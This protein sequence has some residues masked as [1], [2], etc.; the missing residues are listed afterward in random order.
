MT[1]SKKNCFKKSIKMLLFIFLSL[2]IILT[3]SDLSYAGTSYPEKSSEPIRI[4]VEDE[5]ESKEIEIPILSNSSSEGLS[6][7]DDSGIKIQK[8][9]EPELF[10]SDLG[11]YCYYDGKIEYLDGTTLVEYIKISLYEGGA[12]TPYFEYGK[13]YKVTIPSGA[14]ENADSNSNNSDLIYIFTAPPL[15]ESYSLEIDNDNVTYQ[16]KVN[17]GTKPNAGNK[18]Y[19]YTIEE[20]QYIYYTEGLE[21]EDPYRLAQNKFTVEEIQSNDFQTKSISTTTSASTT[22]N[23]DTDNNISRSIPYVTALVGEEPK[24]DSNHNDAYLNY[25]I[26]ERGVLLDQLEV[27]PRLEEPRDVVIYS[28]SESDSTS[29]GYDYVLVA[30]FD[31]NIE[32][33]NIDV[34][35]KLISIKFGGKF[36]P[37]EIMN[38]QAAV[39]DNKL[40]IKM[41][42]AEFSDTSSFSINIPDGIIRNTGG[43]SNHEIMLVDNYYLPNLGS[44]DLGGI[45]EGESTLIPISSTAAINLLFKNFGKSFNKIISTGT[46]DGSSFYGANE[47]SGLAV[48]DTTGTFSL[49][50]SVW[51]Y[52][53]Y[54]DD[55]YAVNVLGL[56]PETE[57]TWVTIFQNDGFD[58]NV[59]IAQGH[60]EKFTTVPP[61]DTVFLYID[62]DNGMK[63]YD[64]DII[65][66]HFDQMI[67]SNVTSDMFEVKVNLGQNQEVTLVPDTDYSVINA[68]GLITIVLNRTAM[69]Y[70]KECIDDNSLGNVSAV[71]VSIID[72]TDFTPNISSDYLT[73]SVTVTLEDFT[74]SD[75]LYFLKNSPFNQYDDGF[76]GRF[77]DFST[78]EDTSYIDYGDASNYEIQL[79]GDSN[80]FKTIDATLTD[81]D[82]SIEKTAS[83]ELKF[84]L[85]DSGIL[86][87]KN[88]QANFISAKAICKNSALVTPTISSD[89]IF[90]MILNVDY[91]ET[92]DGGGIGPYTVYD[93]TWNPEDQKIIY[94][95]GDSIDS[96][97]INLSDIRLDLF[98]GADEVSPIKTYE[99]EFSSSR[100]ELGYIT[101]QL[102]EDMMNDMK[103]QTESYSNFY[104][105][106]RINS[107]DFDDEQFANRSISIS[108]INL[109]EDVINLDGVSYDTGTSDLMDYD[110]KVILTFSGEVKNIG[111]SN[112][113]I[114]EIDNNAVNGLFETADYTVSPLNFDVSAGETSDKVAIDI[115]YYK[116]AYFE[117]LENAV[118]RV[119]VNNGNNFLP[120]I[121]DVYNSN[122]AVIPNRIAEVSSLYL[123]DSSNDKVFNV[124]NFDKDLMYYTIPFLYSEY[125]SLMTYGAI[126]GNLVSSTSATNG[127]KDEDGNFKLTVT[128]EEGHISNEYEIHAE[129]NPYLLKEI[130]VNGTLI[131]QFDPRTKSY[132]I[133]IYDTDEEPT[134]TYS[135]DNGIPETIAA[136]GGKQ[137]VTDL[138]Y[139]YY[140]K[141]MDYFYPDEENIVGTYN[142]IVTKEEEPAPPIVI[143]G[144]DEYTANRTVDLALSDP[145]AISMII[146]ENSE[147]LNAQWEDY[148]ESETFELSEGDGTKTVYVKFG[149]EDTLMPESEVSSDT[150]IYDSTGPENSSIYI[151]TNNLTP[152]MVELEIFSEDAQEMIISENSNFVDANWEPY[153]SYKEFNLSQSYGTKTIYAKFRDHLK[154]ESSVVNANVLIE[155]SNNNNDD[156]DDNKNSS[157]NNSGGTT[158][159]E[160]SQDG[161]YSDLK[162]EIESIGESSDGSQQSTGSEII[163]KLSAVEETLSKIENERL[164]KNALDNL[165]NTFVEIGKSKKEMT[166]E[167]KENADKE[168]E[169]IVEATKRLVNLI[170]E[171]KEVKETVEK[172]LPDIAKMYTEEEKK[173]KS[174]FKILKNIVEIAN[175]SSEK[176]G[177]LEVSKERLEFKDNE[178]ILKP[179]L[180]DI[181]TAAEKSNAEKELLKESMKQIFGEGVDTGLKSS[182]TVNVPDTFKNSEGIGTIIDKETMDELKN[183]NIDEVKVNMGAVSYILD[184]DFIEKKSDFSIKFSTK[185]DSALKEASKEFPK[186]AKSVGSPTFDLNSETN[187]RR[188]N[189]FEKPIVVKINLDN[190]LG[191]NTKG[192]GEWDFENLT[193]YRQEISKTGEIRWVPVNSFYDKESNSLIIPRGHLSK[194]TLLKS[195]KSYSD[196][197]NSWAK[198]EINALKG[199]GVTSEDELFSPESKVT[200]EEFAG[201]I[202]N[203]YGLSGENIESEFKDLNED[204]PYYEAVMAAYSQGIIRGKE[205]DNF[206]P[207]GEVTREEMAVMIANALDKFDTTVNPETVV[208]A[209]YEVD[210]PDWAK[211]SA[212]KLLEN[213][214]VEETY[215]GSSENVSKEEAASIIYSLYR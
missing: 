100:N 190:V 140:I 63:Y 56:M 61:T 188:D 64:D 66:L 68:G 109:V 134:I 74:E 1:I 139:E 135:L 24:V 22:F 161:V 88:L 97:N 75:E 65:K 171:P 82:F 184:R 187:G 111:I 113:Y 186:N 44:L 129:K 198:N 71:E 164:A 38:F 55:L 33:S 101:L 58:P 4:Y 179:T 159:D 142:V 20:E 45:D 162:D 8:E 90:G 167:E 73:N 43:N 157:G 114:I 85:Y 154:N 131:N 205:N 130:K 87:I 149:Y 195:T 83:G 92:K 124:S 36:E 155:N 52:I 57:Y 143:N 59:D 176:Q 175:V 35:N 29:F 50:D 204:S 200:R 107:E 196:V 121:S 173:N 145:S 102:S 104:L 60:L 214:I 215:F 103:S 170:K 40:L 192:F 136:L 141:I 6:I 115:H 79:D 125:N 21:F 201:W 62:Y 76:Y 153:G 117:E 70:M 99:T 51:S 174:T 67:Y 116:L 30:S 191:L 86:K 182:V 69:D 127:V 48:E 95:F 160:T 209:E 178:V 123:T 49:G 10:I 148:S 110:D 183:N 94:H 41:N 144:G 12:T 213:G 5:Y 132:D 16:M 91:L 156:D 15:V 118:V 169:K 105:K 42:S 3:F 133:M 122:T 181:K 84:N 189:V 158:E 93:A 72:P 18:M 7:I 2:L 137:K 14:I 96:Y 202:A 39:H 23:F 13:E 25:G 89:E 53:D 207:S 11:A 81:T 26:A 98:K 54:T 150:I 185:K 152:F 197:E 19:C 46:I 177:L 126:S 151:S 37:L 194:Y 34:L 166:D 27:T 180:N 47:L 146:S 17:T 199:K 206:D 112:N 119:T 165:G 163:E 78:I 108:G 9:G 80:F 77:H 211:D 193:P 120:G 106:L 28:L 147:F 168:S 212:E 203:A 138:G 172:L 208:L 31:S 128:A 210:M 32:N